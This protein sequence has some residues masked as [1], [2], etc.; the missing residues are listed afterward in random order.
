MSGK[1]KPGD[2]LEC[3]GFTVVVGCKHILAAFP[4]GVLMPADWKCWN[5]EEEKR[6][7][8]KHVAEAE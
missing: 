6:Q 8:R 5:C 7:A 3:A 1:P 2:R 4:E